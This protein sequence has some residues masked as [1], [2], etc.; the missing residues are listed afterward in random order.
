M[1]NSQYDSFLFWRQPI[2]EL[3]L[4]ELEDLDLDLDLVLT[5][6]QPANGSQGRDK[7]KVWSPEDEVRPRS[8][9]WW[10]LL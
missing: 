3:E 2:P 10:L 6:S 9:D 5:N 8:S 1:E 4:S 7:S